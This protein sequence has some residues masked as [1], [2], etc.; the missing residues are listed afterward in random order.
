LCSFT[1]NQAIE[2]SLSR[3]PFTEK[4]IIFWG[5]TDF[6]KTTVEFLESSTQIVYAWISA[7]VIFKNELFALRQEIFVED[8]EFTSLDIHLDPLD[9]IELFLEFSSPEILYRPML[10]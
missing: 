3:V 4:P 9:K 1:E 7:G 10:F 2:V 6:S 5:I 8:T